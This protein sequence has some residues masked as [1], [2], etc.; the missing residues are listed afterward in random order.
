MVQKVTDAL[1]YA[2]TGNYDRNFD[3]GINQLLDGLLYFMREDDN[4]DI[5]LV[6]HAVA[7]SIYTLLPAIPFYDV[8]YINIVGGDQGMSVDIKGASEPSAMQKHASNTRKTQAYFDDMS[9]AGSELSVATGANNIDDPEVYGTQAQKDL[10]EFVRNNSQISDPQTSDPQT[11]GTQ[12]SGAQMPDTPLRASL[13]DRRQYMSS[14]SGAMSND[15][16]D[17]VDE[18]TV[19][20]PDGAQ[21][22]QSILTIL[23]GGNYGESFSLL[24]PHNIAQRVLFGPQSKSLA[25]VAKMNLD[26]PGPGTLYLPEDN[27]APFLVSFAAGAPIGESLRSHG[28]KNLVV[29]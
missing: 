10:M 13:D 25:A 18:G 4:G 17:L 27:S 29:W 12:T 7:R 2:L 28:E 24:D 26:P 23:R 20:S 16:Q 22:I 14:Y 9:Q 15:L 3:G 5:S 21:E 8:A 19:I 11:S 6:E 1:Q